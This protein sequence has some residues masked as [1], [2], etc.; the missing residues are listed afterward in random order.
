MAYIPGRGERPGETAFEVYKEGLSESCSIADIAASR[1]FRGGLEFYE[2]GYYWEA[3]ELWEAVWMCL[4]Q[5]SA[6]RHLLRGIIQL[7]NA[8]LKRA[9]DRPA[10]AERI[11]ALADSALAEAFLHRSDC[12]M[13]LSNDDVMA[14][15]ERI[16][17]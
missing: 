12:L 16:A 17:S 15:R 10:A 5:A 1:A 4:P 2:T 11:L 8:G 7:A 14:L 6:E 9:M 13:G 3:H